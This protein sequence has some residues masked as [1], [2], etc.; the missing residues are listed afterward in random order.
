MPP[1]ENTNKYDK[2]IKYQQIYEIELDIFFVGGS[3]QLYIPIPYYIA[4]ILEKSN[5][6]VVQF[7]LHYYVVALKN[8][9]LNRGDGDALYI[10]IELITL[11][12]AILDLI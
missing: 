11:K 8:Q 10:N 3:C 7:F 5:K 12:A 2:K 9:L 6:S 1:A 4:K